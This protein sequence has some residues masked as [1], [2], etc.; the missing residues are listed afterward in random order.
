MTNP[1]T[2]PLSPP[3]DEID[4]NPARADMQQAT[5]TW[6]AHARQ[7][8][9]ERFGA[10][11]EAHGAKVAEKMDHKNRLYA[12]MGAVAMGETV[13]VKDY[14]GPDSGL[15]PDNPIP[16]KARTRHER[17][18]DKKIF[19]AT[20]ARNEAIADDIVSNF[21]DDIRLGR[22]KRVRNTVRTH[23]IKHDKSLSAAERATALVDAK[24][25]PAKQLS[26]NQRDA[27]R[28]LKSSKSVLRRAANQTF[29]TRIA[30]KATNGLIGVTPSE[31][32]AARIATATPMAVVR[33]RRMERGIGQIQG[34][35]AQQEEAIEK[36]GLLDIRR[37]VEKADAATQKATREHNKAARSANRNRANYIR[38]EKKLQNAEN[39]I[40]TAS[41]TTR[42]GKLRLAG[43]KARRAVNQ[44]LVDRSVKRGTDARSKVAN[45]RT[46]IANAQQNA[47]KV[48][49][50]FGL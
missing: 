43:T 40:N 35:H 21:S 23:G 27:K 25:K 16:P 49:D 9:I 3:I 46:D 2:P 48:R 28:G 12:Y 17:K 24:S 33:T 50:F 32:N 45:R 20:A 7:A 29:G 13:D 22:R 6:M 5:A 34:A 11:R 39:R 15:D 1:N 30:A 37:E 41:P 47:D 4:A 8:A 19:K 14:A 26:K 42:R 10:A 38:R 44:R 36:Q 18:I 31:A